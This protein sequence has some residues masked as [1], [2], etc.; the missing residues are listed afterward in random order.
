MFYGGRLLSHLS[1][2]DDDYSELIQLRNLNRNS[3][4]VI[5]SDRKSKNDPINATKARLKD[6]F[7]KP[8]GIVWITAGREI[9]NYIEHAKLQEAVAK[10]HAT[11]YG[12]PH[13]G[14]P[15]DHAL[16]FWKAEVD[17]AKP[18]IEKTVNKVEVS[19]EVAEMGDADLDILDLKERLD[20]LIKFIR[21]ANL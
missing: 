12:K 21:N 7:A 20:E 11:K 4:M 16:H 1:G 18:E 6:E 15:F 2:N 8:P 13:K 3:A 14:G 9:E 17:A 19:R 10:V 5:D